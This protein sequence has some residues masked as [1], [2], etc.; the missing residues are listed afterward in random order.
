MKYLSKLR[1]TTNNMPVPVT[2]IFA[3]HNCP[4]AIEGTAD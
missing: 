1:F 3:K 2:Q 4:E